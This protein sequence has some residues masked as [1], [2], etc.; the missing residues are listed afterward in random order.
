M[1]PSS[2]LGLEMGQAHV[3]KEIKLKEMSLDVD[4]KDK[5]IE[6]FLL[7]VADTERNQY[8]MVYGL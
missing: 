6:N 4:Y 8:A 1:D 3:L 2:G 7:S 5:V